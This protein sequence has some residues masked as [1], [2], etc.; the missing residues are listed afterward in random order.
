MQRLVSRMLLE[1]FQRTYLVVLLGLVWIGFLF[2]T[3]LISQVSHLYWQQAALWSSFVVSKVLGSCP[4]FAG[5]PV[6]KVVNWEM[7]SISYSLKLD[8]DVRDIPSLFLLSSKTSF[9]LSNKH[10]VKWTP[11]YKIKGCRWGEERSHPWLQLLNFHHV[12]QASSSP[13]SKF[14]S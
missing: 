4:C 7:L 2:F 3:F 13:P 6:L 5:M 9:S 10:Y 14:I 12:P 1:W 11:V 8:W